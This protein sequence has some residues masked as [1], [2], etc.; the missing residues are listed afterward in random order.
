M[1]LWIAG[2]V[3]GL[4]VAVVASNRAVTNAVGLAAHLGASPFVIGV[5]VLAVGTDL[6]EIAN[7]IWSSATDRG[8]LNVG[9]SV[10]SVITQL[11]LALGATCL[12]GQIVASR[13]RVLVAGSLIVGAL[14]LG[15]LLV[16]D[17]QVT[18]VEAGSLLLVW[19][20]GTI[21]LAT[22]GAP[23]PTVLV[24]ERGVA[25]S[26]V[27]LLAS[28]A[29]VGAGAWI[30][31][32]S[33]ARLAEDI[34]VPEYLA[35]FFLL[36]LGTS[37]PELVVA[38]GAVRRGESELALGDLLGASFADATLSLGI[39]PLLFPIVVDD[40]AARGGLVAAVTAALVVAVLARN[41]VHGRATAVVLLLLYGSLYVSLLT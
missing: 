24:T 34:G 32:E 15:A 23:S 35:S 10:G 31:V 14:A 40:D 38:A 26:I 19:V 27:V 37:L 29:V 41:R 1:A 28:L 5:T 13:R 6:P 7:S 25:R 33:F 22:E 39:G 21:V 20:V 8:D 3:G 17:E 4:V 12:V 2:V 16:L 9:D 30:A 18:R 11:T 36:A